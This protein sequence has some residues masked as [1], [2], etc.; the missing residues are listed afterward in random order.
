MLRYDE[1]PICGNRKRTVSKTCQKCRFHL[2]DR[3]GQAP[4]PGHIPG[5]PSE[6]W[7][8]EFRGLFWG[9]GS[10][11]IVPN[12]RSYSVILALNLRIDDLELVQDIQLK[13][14]GFLVW[15]AS[16]AR[17]NPNASPQAQWRVSRLTHVLEIC[18]LLLENSVLSA[19]K[20]QD[21]ELVL[22]FCKWRLPR[23]GSPLTEEERIEMKRRCDELRASR[24][25]S[26][27]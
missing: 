20:K 5:K 22:G 14:G 23:L 7:L 15:S 10:A 8:Q 4:D 2:N 26:G 6:E 27:C 12:N 11:M 21:V 9:E 18:E 24:I 17:Q 13:L 3:P 19:K 25:V 16:A 1:C